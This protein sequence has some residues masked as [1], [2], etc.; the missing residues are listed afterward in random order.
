M[1]RYVMP[2]KIQIS[3]DLRDEYEIMNHNESLCR[4]SLLSELGDNYIEKDFADDE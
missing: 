4:T 3:L 2:H 1:N